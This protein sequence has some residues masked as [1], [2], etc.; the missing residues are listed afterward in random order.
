MVLEKMKE[1][2]E[3]HLTGG[4]R[5]AVI[6]VPAYFNDS[7]RQATKDAGKIA[8]LEV[9]RII[10]E[11]TAASLGYGVD[12]GDGKII[13]IY[14]LGGGTFDLS[15]LEISGGVFEVKATNGDTLLG[16][17][18]FDMVL[19][20]HLVETFKKQ[21]GI[22]LKKD[23]MAVE[24]LRDASEKAKRELDGLKETDINLPYI[25][26]DASGP[27]HLAMK[28]TRTQF[29]N[30]T[31][32]LVDRT[33]G[34]CE[35]CL[36]DAGV[37]KEQISEVLLVGGMSRMPRVQELVHKFF[38]K[39]PNKGVNPD[40]VVA[41]GAAIQGGVLKG[42]VEDIVLLDVT[43]LSLGIETLGGV[44]TTLIPRNTTIPTKKSQIFSTAADN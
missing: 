32:E 29:E 24:R 38:G 11:P 19:L 12:K 4:V 9:D 37:T 41:A 21:T 34:P 31:Q 26:A 43:P 3:N 40:E 35:K 10:N 17:E 6:T 30:M 7:Q 20:N 39:V 28:I 22:D 36:K 25:T 27:K 13:A 33:L 5:H 2:A 15:L 16:G 1:T 18:D 42:E 8:G 23:P 14:D 44:F